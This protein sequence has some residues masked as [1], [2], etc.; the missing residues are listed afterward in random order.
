M[1]AS[2]LIDGGVD[3]CIVLLHIYQVMPLPSPF[4]TGGAGLA[5][6]D[7]AVASE[8]CVRLE[9]LAD[10]L[11]RDVE[12]MRAER[13]N[14]PTVQIETVVRQD[15]PCEGILAEARE[16]EV[17]RIAVGSHGHTGLMHFLLGSTAERVVRLANI[18]VLVV[19]GPT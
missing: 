14:A 16:R 4:D 13:L 17:E 8:S 10:A 19:K 11:R 6:M 1:A 12:L 15:G 3:G 2:D 5:A 18:P 9:R 7:E